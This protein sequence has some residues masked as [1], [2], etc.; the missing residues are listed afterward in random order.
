MIFTVNGSETDWLVYA[1][2]LEDQGTDS[3]HIREGVANPYT[4]QWFSEVSGHYA[5]A[6]CG[7][8]SGRV[9][10]SVPNY[11][12]TFSYRV[13]SLDSGRVGSNESFVGSY[14]DVGFRRI[15]IPLV[16]RIYPQLLCL[17]LTAPIPIGSS[18]LIT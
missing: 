1:D 10:A 15:S 16:R 3:T 9:G 7:Q 12:D 13:G 2:Y 17:I 4:N 11:L 14:A 8:N 6:G 5:G 18:M